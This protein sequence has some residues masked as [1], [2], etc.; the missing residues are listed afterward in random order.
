MN[1]KILIS[2]NKKYDLEERTAK[3]AE[4][5][6]DHLKTVAETTIN[7]SIIIQLI[8][9]VTSIAANYCEADGAES[10]KDFKHKIA[11]CKKECKEVK[12]WLRLMSNIDP[13]NTSTYRSFWQEAQE[14]TLIFS[15]IS[16]KVRQ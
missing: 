11:I 9:A 7:K 12:L 14:L 2:N 6:L 15:A 10:K 1:D 8:R 16:K 13:E 3:F 4:K 5:V